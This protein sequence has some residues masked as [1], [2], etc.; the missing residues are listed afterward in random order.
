VHSKYHPTVKARMKRVQR[1]DRCRKMANPDGT[2]SIVCN[3]C[4][5]K[6]HVEDKK[7]KCL[8]RDDVAQMWLKRMRIMNGVEEDNE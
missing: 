7:P 1:V 5:T 8:T 4:E 3:R 6:W 2:A